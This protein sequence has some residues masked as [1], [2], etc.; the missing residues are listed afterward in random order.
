MGTIQIKNLSFR[1]DGMVNHIF[2]QFSLSIDESWKLG[3][4]GR[5]GRGKTTFLNLLLGK[6][7]YHGE[8]QS[9][10]RFNYF[11]QPI[12]DFTKNVVDVLMD[13][14]G[15]N[16]SEVWKIQLEMDQLGLTDDLLSRPFSTL[17]PGEQ[18]KAL[19]AAMF[20]DKETFQL[21]DEPT[22]HLDI[23]GRQVVASYLKSKRGFIVVSHDRYFIDQVIDHV[24]SIDR[25]KIQLFDGNYDTWQREF[26]R[27]NLSE[28]N[29]KAHLQT[30]IKRLSATASQVKQ[31]A[32]NAE[33][34]KSKK[35][36]GGQS[37]VN[38]D[39]GFLGHK[40]AKVMKRS[41]STLKRTESAI[42]E[43]KSLLRN[44]DDVVPLTL[45]YKQP[46]QDHILLLND[47]QVQRNHNILNE[48]I[49][50]DLTKDQR[51]VFEGPNGFGK[52]T[53]I[54][55]ILGEKRLIARGSSS[56]SKTV[57]VSYLTQEFETLSGSIE[58][59]AKHHDV[60][61]PVSLNMLKKLGFERSAFTEDLSELSMGQKRK[62]SLAR[63]L[64]EPAN[65]YIWDE[66]LNYLDVI[67][68]RQIQKLILKVKPTMLLIDHDRDFVDAIATEPPIELKKYR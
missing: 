16:E 64:C 58:A 51:L 14:S 25:A 42:D 37:N 10:L 56:F 66:P 50:F 13:V 65:F 53:M 12:T 1:Y 36:Y 52:T 67:T 59:Y 33:N 28:K 35:A 3:L 20:T 27:E 26:D 47:F 21:I 44:I 18:T 24:L 17:S 2:D 63:S 8:I 11:P 39:K 40:A 5:N 60:E 22:N 46:H 62:V 48:P 19:L 38:L 57:K 7:P 49:T 30:E 55:A 32:G 31:W 34:K 54:K 23:A 68:R 29:E 61:L 45:N 4:I 6:Y 43:K 41:K 15:L 9:N